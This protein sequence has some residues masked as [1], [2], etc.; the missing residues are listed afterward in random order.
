MYR[1]AEAALDRINEIVAKCPKDLQAKCFEVLLSGYVQI[2]VGSLRP[3][4]APVTDP[5]GKPKQQGTLPPESPIPPSSLPRFKSTAKRLGVAIERLESLFDFNVDPFALHPVTLPGK[6]N[7]EKTRQVALLAA[8]RS[9]L[10]TG[11]WSADWPEVKSLCVDQN[12]YDRTN[13]AMNLKQGSGKLF[14]PVTSGKQILLSTDGIR[15]AE[16]L[17]KG[18]AEGTSA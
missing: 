5:G 4:Q 10:A 3:S 8:L 1:N 16:E 15:K 14:K 18:L 12:C 17:V 9:Y 2:E 13:H 7:A 6:N 11:S